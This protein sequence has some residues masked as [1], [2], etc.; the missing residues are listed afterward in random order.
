MRRSLL[1]ALT[2][3]LTL[4][5]TSSAL[6]QSTE[7]RPDMLS[8]PGRVEIGGGGSVITAFSNGGFLGPGATVTVNFNARHGLQL[9][10]D[11]QY[12]S[13]KHSWGFGGIYSILYRYTL[14]EKTNRR[15][16]LLA[17]V[18]GL[19]Q[20]QH[21]KAHSTSVPAYT[22]VRNGVPVEYAARTY[23]YPKRTQ[24]DAT[25]PAAA[26]VGFGAEVRAARRLIL[27]GQVAVGA[28]PFVPVALR[29]S[30]GAAIP[31]GQVRR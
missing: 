23:D 26:V 1:A 7:N 17:G 13:R 20:I 31:L 5:L 8:V 29:V 2:L 30:A 27:Q 25:V 28:S 22:V 10:A 11:A 3:L 12:T 6:A 18:A 4:G 16:F 15:T 24:W 19:T 9:G 21:Y 14:S